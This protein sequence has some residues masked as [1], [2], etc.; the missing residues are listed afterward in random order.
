MYD[1]VRLFQ[2]CFFSK[3][4]IHCALKIWYLPGW[5]QVL[6]VISHPVCCTVAVAGCFKGQSQ[7]SLQMLYISLTPINYLEKKPLWRNKG[8]LNYLRIVS[9]AW[10]WQNDV[11]QASCCESLCNFTSISPSV[12]THLCVSADDISFSSRVEVTEFQLS[13]LIGGLATDREN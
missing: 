8:R 10:R 13:A 11:R 7:G 5:T 2:S 12:S 1:W 9:V 3:H 4:N 6:A